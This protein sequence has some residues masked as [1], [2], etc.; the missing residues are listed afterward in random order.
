MQPGCSPA[1]FA[2]SSA[3]ISNMIGLIDPSALQT[4]PLALHANASTDIRQLIELS[5][6]EVAGR[7]RLVAEAVHRLEELF[8]AIRRNN[9]L[10]KALPATTAR[11]RQASKR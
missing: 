1:D 5:K 4:N 8:A 7:L 6:S 2:A 11:R 3:K 9:S 10:M